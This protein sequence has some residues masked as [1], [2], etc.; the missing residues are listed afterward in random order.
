MKQAVE[1]AT[2]NHR[3]G[4]IANEK[5][6]EAEYLG[7][8]CDI[9][10][11]FVEWVLNISK[12][13]QP[14]VYVSHHAVKVNPSF[15]L[16]WQGLKKQVH[17]KRLAAADIAPEVQAGN[18]VIFTGHSQRAPQYLQRTL[19]VQEARLQI[20]KLVYDKL[21]S[22]ITCVSLL[23]EAFSVCAA[24]V[25]VDRVPGIRARLQ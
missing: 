14:P 21:L 8:S 4:D 12:R 13:F 10:C 18:V 15:F 16:Q 19:Y 6:I 9:G 25:H 22:G 2:Q 24:Y 5:L 11:D 7:L 3:V 20:G 17:Q 1:Q 23:L